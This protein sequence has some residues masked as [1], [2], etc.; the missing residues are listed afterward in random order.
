[1][2]KYLENLLKQGEK[3]LGTVLY[4]GAGTGSELAGISSLE[5]KKIV[6]VEASLELY[7]ALKR[8]SKKYVNVSALNT[9]VLP[10]GQ[11]TAEVFLYNNPRYNSLGGA[12]NF[13]SVD[14]NV[15]LLERMTV[16]GEP[17]DLLIA[18]LH[19]DTNTANLLVVD[20]PNAKDNLLLRA[21]DLYLQCFDFLVLVK[22][23][24]E[25]REDE[26]SE[27]EPLY[28]FEKM[29]STNEEILP[30]DFFVRNEK[31][32][33][34]LLQ[35]ELKQELEKV[36]EE[37]LLQVAS[38]NEKLEHLQP[39]KKQVDEEVVKLREEL[40]SI[41]QKS[42][43]QAENDSLKYQKHEVKIEE[44]N[45]EISELETLHEKAVNDLAECSKERDAEHKWH[46]EH[47]SWAESLSSQQTQL[48]AELEEK[49]SSV[50]LSQKM[51]AKAQ[52]DL[53]NLREK[54]SE[55]LA[56]ER[57]LI[58]LVKELREKLTIASK[59]YFKLQQEHPELLVSGTNGK[60]N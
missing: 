55:K 10:P 16:S 30:F 5:P 57:E 11:K 35:L 50:S 7:S 1:M 52:I 42:Q 18:A 49:S 20:T 58:D 32:C 21:K 39:A 8:K 33:K 13:K 29:L 26:H 48:K 12:D 34:L 28:V 17:L 9:W 47:K 4:I 38:L 43:I 22:G 25:D 2:K 36:N 23:I 54:Y 3:P 37:Q 41:K 59:Y 45:A 53:D 15:K 56:S 6:A 44:L 27:T 60:E 19:L 51:Y 14:S 46:K 24:V 31:I 40:H